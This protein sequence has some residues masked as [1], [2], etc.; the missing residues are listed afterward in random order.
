[1]VSRGLK[2]YQVAMLF[3]TYPNMT[4][5]PFAQLSQFLNLGVIVLNIVFLREAGWVVDSNIAA[6]TVEDS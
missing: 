1:M 6:E 4:I 2:G 3:W 5:T